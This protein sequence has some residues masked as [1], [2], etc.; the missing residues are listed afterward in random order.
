MELLIA[1]VFMAV[2][3]LSMLT[4]IRTAHEHADRS[5][6]RMIGLALAEDRI[7]QARADARSGAVS[8][9]VEFE[10]RSN[11]GIPVNVQISRNISLV[12][13]TTDLY[14][15]IVTVSWNDPNAVAVAQESVKLQTIVRSPDA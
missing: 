1:T 15:V 3:V 2:A 9:G 11:T 10:S 14:L 13:G 8:T 6:Y 7:E 12:S 4:G 5:K